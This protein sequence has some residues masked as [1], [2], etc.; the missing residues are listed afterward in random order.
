MRRLVGLLLDSGPVVVLAVIAGAGS[1]THIRDTAAQHGQ[2]GPMAWA[3]A[4]CVDLTC[5]MAARE[6]QRDKRIGRNAGPVS[7]P[8]LV[9]VGGI[10]LSLAA[11]LAQ[12]GPSAWGRVVAA[13]PAGAFL[14]A[15]SML[16]RRSSG[17]RP[18]SSSAGVP[19]PAPPSFGRPPDGR[20]DEPPRQD[21]RVPSGPTPADSL[22]AYARRVADEHHQRHGRPITRDALRAR[23]GVSNQLASDLLR[24]IRT[25]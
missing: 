15:V 4:V 12:A 13:T 21:E 2:R 14:V 1:F 8:T 10:T 24:Q 25:A 3:V 17:R 20:Q 19:S 5:V 16:E 9:L 22:V 18:A 23:L 7:W 6:R 11:N